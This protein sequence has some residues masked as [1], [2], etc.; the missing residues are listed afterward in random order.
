MTNFEILTL[1]FSLLSL[2][3]ILIAF[4]VYRRDVQKDS[5][6]KAKEEGLQQ[7]WREKVSNDIKAAHDKI[8]VHDSELN[9][10][11]EQSHDSRLR[12]EQLSSLLD[13]SAKDIE[14]TRGF[15]QSF[16]LAMK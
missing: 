11:K 12:L 8:R 9:G 10:V 5:L 1:V 2:V 16:I 7:A 15:V 6:A 4:L 14:D 13:R 3:G